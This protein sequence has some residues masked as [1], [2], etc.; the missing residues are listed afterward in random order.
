MQSSLAKNHHWSGR[1][2]IAVVVPILVVVLV[3]IGLTSPGAASAH[4]LWS[5]LATTVAQAQANQ[6]VTPI[7]DVIQ[8]ANQEQTAALATNTPSQM[9]D[10]A[11]TTASWCRPTSRSP[12]R[13]PR[14]SP[15]SV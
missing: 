7:Q 6:E 1:S 5:A 15:S 4:Q 12:R 8:Q 11:P 3:A 14:A 2:R 10:T 9:S 13:V